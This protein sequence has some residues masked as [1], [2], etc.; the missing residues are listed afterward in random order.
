MEIC[1]SP[2]QL[3]PQQDLEKLASECKESR[4][5][6]WTKGNSVKLKR[7]LALKWPWYVPIAFNR[8]GFQFPVMFLHP[9]QW[10]FQCFHSTAAFPG[11]TIETLA[12]NERTCVQRAKFTCHVFFHEYG[13]WNWLKPIGSGTQKWSVWF[14]PHRRVCRILFSWD[15]RESGPSGPGLLRRVASTT[16]AEKLWRSSLWMEPSRWA[17]RVMVQ[18]FQFFQAS[19]IEINWF[20]FIRNLYH[21]VPSRLIFR[22]LSNKSTWI[23]SHR[24]PCPD[25]ASRVEWNLNSRSKKSLNFQ[26]WKQSDH[27]LRDHMGP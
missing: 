6:S 27:L 13:G 18:R 12:R 5:Q 21:L 14:Q 10:D 20:K 22:N 4:P 3:D 26:S 11:A 7:K 16:G 19:Q 8:H 9:I 25:Q 23:N 24:N 2:E 17:A 15:I 1:D